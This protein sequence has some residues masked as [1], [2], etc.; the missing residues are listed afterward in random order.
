M[1]IEGSKDYGTG[2]ILMLGDGRSVELDA[3][4]YLR[5]NYGLHPSDGTLTHEPATKYRG[6][7]NRESFYFIP[8]NK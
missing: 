7:K 1:I 6:M 8:E 4:D 2:E 5:N 3:W